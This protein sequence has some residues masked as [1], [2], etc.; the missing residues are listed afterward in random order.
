MASLRTAIARMP[1]TRYGPKKGLFIGLSCL[2]ALLG[3]PDPANG[4]A[5]PGPPSLIDNLDHAELTVR[6][7]NPS[8]TVEVVQHVADPSQ[9]RFGSSAERLVYRAAPGESAIFTIRFHQ[10]VR[11]LDDCLIHCWAKCSRPGLVIAAN[12]VLPRS[13][14][15]KTGQ[16]RRLLVR[17]RPVRD[18]GSWQSLTLDG[19][20]EAVAAQARVARAAIR[21]GSRIDEREAYVDQ[22]MLLAPGGQGVG[23]LIVD[24]LSVYG[25]LQRAI[26][27]MAA[28][29]TNVGGPGPLNPS[30]GQTESHSS[31]S[32]EVASRRLGFT[33]ALQWQGEPLE[34][35][36]ELGFDVLWFGR[37]PQPAELD[38]AQRLGMS[39]ICPPASLL[40]DGETAATEVS[41]HL[42]VLAWDLGE[43]L[44]ETELLEA[45]Q[46]RRRLM[47]R[48][49]SNRPTIVRPAQRS[50]EASRV[51]DML[52]LAEPLQGASA[53]AS[54]YFRQ[55]LLQQRVARPG[56]GVWT[57]AQSHFDVHQQS[58]LAA[59]RGGRAS[60]VPTGYG[61]LTQQINASLAVRPKG[62]LFESFANLAAGDVGNEIRSRALELSVRR[63]QLLEPWLSSG[64]PATSAS[65]SA[66]DLSGLVL[67]VERS[68]II[69]PTSWRAVDSSGLQENVIAFRLPGVPETAQAYLI[70]PAGSQRL[71]SRRVAGGLQ[72][73]VEQLPM[74]GFILATE[75]G[76]AFSQVERHIR[77]FAVRASQLRHEMS[78]LHR[79]QAAAALQVMPQHIQN[80]TS[81]QESLRRCDRLLEEAESLHARRDWYAVYLRAAAAEELLEQLA[82]SLHREVLP[83]HRP[84][85]FAISPAW[86]SL[87]DAVRIAGIMASA[88]QRP[89]PIDGGE[90]EEIGQ[91]LESGWQRLQVETPGVEPAVRLSPEA[92][93][94]GS[95]SL[96]L[97]VSRQ[98]PQASAP[99]IATAP[100]VV[101]SP[102]I[103]LPR[104]GLVEISGLVRTPQ[105]LVGPADALLIYESLGGPAL[106][107]RVQDARQW[108]PFRL[109]R[110]APHGGSTQ[111]TLAL[112]GLGQVQ[113]DAIQMRVIPLGLP[114][115]PAPEQA[116]GEPASPV[117]SEMAQRSKR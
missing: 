98:D 14:D 16:P 19:L 79:R 35:L 26:E 43:T 72:I 56:T 74:D 44:T 45:D 84:G 67:Q 68:H 106:A 66:D 111:I 117:R 2:L 107:V 96:E 76:R 41:Q 80:S 75:D 105:P 21:D 101:R 115:R 55:L 4:Q 37:T 50:R 27:P 112:R 52:L 103:E 53:S 34:Q 82:T 86:P 22:V 25:V 93:A 109:V 40:V 62:I 28:D 1:I 48:D 88:N 71:R 17:R 89:A 30:G 59:L 63:L 31:P 13:L 69:V 54:E 114:H 20:S 10:N 87:P 85:E 36:Q 102:R 58:Q 7:S 42:A 77:Q 91:V 95:Y 24:Q 110:A 5:L 3:I 92:P 47:R 6:L 38:E 78:Q 46:R 32:I 12:V 11:V 64:A 100:V 99:T 23:E 83:A 61:R 49:R 8:R 73:A 57:T 97:E 33:F 90:F 108:E 39:L 60:V 116:V 51:A 94:S 104:G 9:R 65:C 29:P 81:V 113:V 70:T 18:V 15:P